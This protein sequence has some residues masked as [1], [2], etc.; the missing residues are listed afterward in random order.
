M[1]EVR[2]GVH[3]DEARTDA[4]SVG[5]DDGRRGFPHV[6]VLPGVPRPVNNPAVPNNSIYHEGTP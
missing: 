6:A 1:C 4:E 5:I 3:V 2:V